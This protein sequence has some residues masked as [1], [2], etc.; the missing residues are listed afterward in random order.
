MIEEIIKTLGFKDEEVVVYLALH[1]HG[2]QMASHLAELIKY[3]RPVT[4]VYLKNLIKGGL[5]K[6]GYS[7][8][9]KVFTAEPAEKLN[10][11]YSRKIDFL[12]K[13]KQSLN[14]ILPEMQKRVK[15]QRL[16]PKLQIYEGRHGIESALEDILTYNDIK[17]YTVWSID[18]AMKISS[19]EFFRYHN[20]ERINKN[21]WID[22]I[23]PEKQ[24]VDPKYFPFMGTGKNFKRELRIAPHEIDT[25][26]GYWIYA[27]KVLCLSS[28]SESY[29]FTVESDEYVKMMQAQHKLIWRLS[30]HMPYEQIANS[31]FLNE[32]LE[33]D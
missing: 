8:S 21:I 1:D 27:N 4:Y 12:N 17:T 6:Q 19:P 29:A 23:W 22:G 25:S 32:L 5:V 28:K 15:A 33:E 26:M 14:N 16:R 11:L 9:V 24:A 20:K 2:T 10:I 18:S 31:S 13:Q 3:K 7:S 30:K